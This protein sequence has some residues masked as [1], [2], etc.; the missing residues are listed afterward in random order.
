M[1]K[2]G[3]HEEKIKEVKTKQ[4]MQ[5]SKK[6]VKKVVESIL[7]ESGMMHKEFEQIK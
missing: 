3:K 6:K 1:P 5:D 7:K 2:M 4:A